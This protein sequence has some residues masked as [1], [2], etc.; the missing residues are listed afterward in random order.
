[1][2]LLASSLNEDMVRSAWNGIK[3]VPPSRIA[4]EFRGRIFLDISN[5]TKALRQTTNLDP[6]RARR[7]RMSRREI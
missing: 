5:I 3:R 1:M 6:S 4:L 2:N 7:T